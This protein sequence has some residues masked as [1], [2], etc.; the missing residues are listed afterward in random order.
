[1]KHKFTLLS[2][3]VGSILGNAAMAG[4][5][6]V[7]FSA[8]DQDRN[9]AISQAE[10]MAA[11]EDAALFNRLDVNDNGMLEEDEA[12]GDLVDYD[13]ITDLDKGGYVD[14][15]EFALAV[16]DRFDK[17]DSNALDADEYE[18]F[19]EQASEALDS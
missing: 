11:M 19:S 7:E 8:L 5:D 12:K 9:G 16:F 3:C 10:L 4:G 2:V 13:E 6:K 15:N 18:D 14:R 1:M 17:D